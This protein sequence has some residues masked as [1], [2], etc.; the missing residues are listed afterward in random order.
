MYVKIID[1][2]QTLGYT[3]RSQWWELGLQQN[4][5]RSD[6]YKVVDEKLFF[7]SVIKYGIKF[8]RVDEYFA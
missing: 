1:F 7:L 4:Y 6:C 3:F 2:Y 8:E 5:M